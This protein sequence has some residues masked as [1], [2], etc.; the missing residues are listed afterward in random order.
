MVLAGRAR[1]RVSQVGLRRPAF[2]GLRDAP[3]VE[4][5]GNPNG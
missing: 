3:G 4:A 2:F 1:V 5:D